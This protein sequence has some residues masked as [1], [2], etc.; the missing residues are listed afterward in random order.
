MSKLPL[1]AVDIGKGVMLKIQLPH[2]E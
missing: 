2:M 1:I